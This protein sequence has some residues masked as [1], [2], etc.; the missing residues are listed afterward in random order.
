MCVIVRAQGQ[1]RII[2]TR[3][4]KV[5]TKLL[6]SQSDEGN[7]ENFETT[8]EISLNC[9]KAHCSYMFITYRAKLLGEAR[10]MP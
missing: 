9:T 8:S 4:S 5:F 2:Y 7:L 1:L 3:I 10:S 6:D